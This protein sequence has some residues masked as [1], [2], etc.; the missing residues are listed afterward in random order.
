[1]SCCIEGCF[2]CHPDGVDPR[3]SQQS[4]TPAPAPVPYGSG[5]RSHWSVPGDRSPGG[6]AGTLMGAGSKFFLLL[7]NGT[8]VGRGAVTR[9]DSHVS[10]YARNLPAVVF[11]VFYLVRKPFDPSGAMIPRIRESGTSAAA[12]IFGCDPAGHGCHGR[13]LRSWKWPFRSP[14]P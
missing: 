6:R 10:K 2:H 9:G 4:R 5:H 13:G 1:M 14:G 12:R 7:M 3:L 8:W 11:F